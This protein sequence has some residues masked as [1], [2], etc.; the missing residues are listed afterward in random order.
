MI[1][2]AVFAVTL[3]LMS[4]IYMYMLSYT[5]LVIMTIVFIFAA[6]FLLF[7]NGVGASVEF[8]NDQSNIRDRMQRNPTL[9]YDE[10][11]RQY[12]AEKRAEIRKQMEKTDI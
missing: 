12:Y 11:S 4:Y 1:D 7:K 9:S 6:L 3:L 5:L 8:S 2:V 10:A